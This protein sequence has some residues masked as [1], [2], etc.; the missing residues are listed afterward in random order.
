MSALEG[1]VVYMELGRALAPT[2][3]FVSAVMSAGVLL[4]AG[5]EEQK[6]RVAAADRHRRRDRHHRLARAAATASARAACRRERRPTA[7]GSCSTA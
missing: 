3:H 6:Q 7:T 1:A 4:R 2:P 5:T